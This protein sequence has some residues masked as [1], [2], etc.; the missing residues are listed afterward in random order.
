MTTEMI[1]VWHVGGRGDPGPVSK[2]LRGSSAIL[3]EANLDNP[4][5]VF[6]GYDDVDD[7]IAAC[8]YSETGTKNFYITRDANASSLYKMSPKALNYEAFYKTKGGGRVL[9]KEICETVE[10][11]K[12][13]TVSLKEM[14]DKY[15]LQSPDVLSLD[16]QGAE[17]DVLIGAGDILDS[18]LGII[19]EVE[20]NE[21][22]ENQPLFDSQHSLLK[23]KGFLL[24]DLFSIQR[25]FH[26]LPPPGDLG[27]LT[28]AE[29]F[30][31]RDYRTVTSLEALKKLVL[32]AR[33][34]DRHSYVNRIEEHI[35]GGV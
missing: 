15:G 5:V 29:A 35:K 6:E 8:I 17:Y 27:M 10:V 13:N 31:M 16:V 2:L 22:Y 28:V 21:I 9:W 11:R 32:I 1:G 26:D 18:L 25:W 33:T 30:Y 19:T 4:E 3:I 23:S 7:T 24:F 12:I 14:Q 20:F 34:Y